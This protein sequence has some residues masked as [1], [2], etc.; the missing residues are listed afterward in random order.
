MQTPIV[1]VTIKHTKNI[2]EVGMDILEI[3]PNN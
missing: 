3:A 2:D 1:N